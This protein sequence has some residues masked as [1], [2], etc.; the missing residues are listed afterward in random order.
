MHATVWTP[1]T[2]ALA[3][4]GAIGRRIARALG[5]GIEGMELTAVSARDHL[6]AAAYLKELGLSVPV[7]P[8]EELADMAEIIVEALPSAA[9]PDVAY[10]A[11]RRGRTLV[12]LSVGTLLDHDDWVEIARENGGQIVVPTGALL[13]L[14]A[15]TAAAE[16][17]IESVRMIT[18]KP[19]RGLAGAPYLKE[20]GID[21]SEIAEPVKLFEGTARKAVQGFPAN[22]NV[23]VAL[24]LAGI[25][26]DRT[27]IE[28]WADPALSRNTHRIEVVAD[29]AT[30]RF[31]IENIPS[32]NPKTGQITALSVITVLRKLGAPLRVGS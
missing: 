10:P 17:T 22:V 23:S 3:G 27:T 7:L 29:S 19:P 2:V 5:D 28:I 26:P 32:E 1:K 21:V 4:F 24:G 18:R 20:R 9:V 30:F 31:E 6:K 8:L 12:L 14:D 15:V 25:G 13:G 11:L 16:G